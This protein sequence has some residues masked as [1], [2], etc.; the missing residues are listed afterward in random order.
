MADK[1]HMIAEEL[2]GPARELRS[3]IPEVLKGYAQLH[4]AATA[5]G[6][7]SKKMKELIALAISVVNKCDG[8]ISS[9][10]RAAAIQGASRDEVAEAIG[11]AIMLSGGPGTVYGPRA[12]E[13][14]LEYQESR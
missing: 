1:Y 7:L 3:E 10:A 13:A 12:F 4:A 9:H 2:R 14:F 6:V 5:E 8:C 11:V